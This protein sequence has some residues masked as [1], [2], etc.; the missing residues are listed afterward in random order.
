MKKNIIRIV[1]NN[2]GIAGF[3]LGVIFFLFFLIWIYDATRATS[4]S[5]IKEIISNK[6]SVAVSTKN[7]CTCYTLPRT[8]IWYGPA[9]NPLFGVKR[10]KYA[11]K[12]C[13]TAY[14][15]AIND[16]D[17]CNFLSKLKYIIL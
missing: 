8:M 1:I 12:E 3:T 5:K 10:T 6:T 9:G 7:P 15:E 14:Y 2:I 16:N 13:L 17:T 4:Q 11:R